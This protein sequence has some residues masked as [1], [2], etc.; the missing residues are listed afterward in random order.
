MNIKKNIANKS[1]YSE[2][3]LIDVSLNKTVKNIKGHTIPAVNRLSKSLEKTVFQ[4]KKQDVPVIFISTPKLSSITFIGETNSKVA[5]NRYFSQRMG[6]DKKNLFH[7]RVSLIP[8]ITINA[9]SIS[10]RDGELIH[11]YQT[12]T[13]GQSSDIVTSK[14]NN[15]IPYNDRISRKFSAKE[16]LDHNQ[17]LIAYPNL[18]NGVEEFVN[19]KNPDSVEGTLGGHERNGT[20]DVFGTITSLSNTSISDIRILGIKGNYGIIDQEASQYDQTRGSSIIDNKYEIVQSSYV[21]FEDSQDAHLAS[22]INNIKKSEEGFISD[23]DYQSSPF[24]DKIINEDK[25]T[26]MSEGKIRLLLSSSNSNFSEIGT[27]YKSM[28]N[29]FTG[30]PVYTSITQNNLGTDSI[31]FRGLL[32]G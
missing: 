30:S 22:S 12:T 20:I 14:N 6:K 17:K 10:Y 26:L 4:D 27:R 9:N 19:F 29:G 28:P 15:F 3:I 32:R 7:L 11:D 21:F 13:Y 23:S 18:T 1:I 8:N 24:S 25:Y 16:F 2:D 31:A 5:K